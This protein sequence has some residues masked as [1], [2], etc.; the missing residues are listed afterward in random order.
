MSSEVLHALK[1]RDGNKPGFLKWLVSLNDASLKLN[2]CTSISGFRSLTG[3]LFSAIEASEMS[4][5]EV[6][7][8]I[9]LIMAFFP[10][11]RY[12]NLK[13]SYSAFKNRDKSESSSMT[14]SQNNIRRIQE[15][16][17]LWDLGSN[18]SAVTR[19]LDMI[20]SQ[21]AGDTEQ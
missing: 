16:V 19:M 20:D 18:N 12:N 2:K 11:N 17:T 13:G 3:S 15:Y 9:T 8:S 1:M 7:D 10:L 21:M 4:L 14:L 5:K 6:D